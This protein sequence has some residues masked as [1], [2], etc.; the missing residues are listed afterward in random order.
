MSAA[1]SLPDPDARYHALKQAYASD[2]LDPAPAAELAD[3]WRGQASLAA[4]PRSALRAAIESLDVA[5]GRDPSAVGLHARKSVVAR[6]LGRV[7]ADPAERDLWIGIAT[8]SAQR[9][10]ELYPSK[11]AGYVELAACRQ[12]A[13]EFSDRADLMRE[14]LAGYQYALA[15]DG[16]RPPWETIRRFSPREI[17]AI[18]A[19]MARIE[20]WRRLRG[21]RSGNR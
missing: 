7:S 10:V 3:W 12:Y 16:Q 21:D 20:A 9:A 11:P 19:E 4:D 15:L 6:A 8:E 18:E 13:G 1:R 14:A 17:A 2:P 5:I